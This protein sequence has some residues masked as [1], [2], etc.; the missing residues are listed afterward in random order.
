MTIADYYK[1]DFADFQLIDVR[2]PVEFEKG[3]IVGAINWPLFSDEERSIV[4]TLYKQ[5]GFSDAMKK[6]LEFVGPKMTKWVDLAQQNEKKKFVIYCWRGGKRSNSM[7]WLLQN[8]GFECHVI[9]SGYKAHR[10]HIITFFTQ[11]ENIVILSAF[12]GSGKTRVISHL[13]EKN[14]QAID[15]EKIANH[16]G[17]T[18]G[19]LGEENQTT[20]EQ[21]QNELFHK[22]KDFDIQKPVYFECESSKIGTVSL[23]KELWKNM[24]NA[25]CF[26]YD[27]PTT[28]RVENILKDYGQYS[29]ELL[30]SAI[31]NLR[32]RYDAQ[33][34]EELE[35]LVISG[36]LN[37]AVAQILPLYDK[38]YKYWFEKRGFTEL[39]NQSFTTFNESEIANN[40]LTEFENG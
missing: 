1:N 26:H 4:G 29:A 9:E 40:L 23:P 17:S 15:L 25:K 5:V 18:F 35:N 13:I 10:N 16:K 2:S 36:N 33:A 20:T 32:N 30:L 3:H 14:S 11:V 8:A 34:F 21:F 37:E 24:Y 12:T 27:I 19:A 38:S 28:D 22:M 31:S 7:A 6:G 39:V